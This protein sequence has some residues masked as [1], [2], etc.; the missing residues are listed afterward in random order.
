MVRTKPHA[1]E[2]SRGSPA[3]TLLRIVGLPSE[4]KK[5]LLTALM[6]DQGFSV[7]PESLSEQLNASTVEAANILRTL[8]SLYE[9]VGEFST[10]DEQLEALEDAL[11]RLDSLTG[12][13]EDVSDVAEA[14]FEFVEPNEQIEKTR[15]RERLREG[16]IPNAI[17]FTS[18]V[19]IRPNFTRVDY[20]PAEVAEFVRQIQFVV[21]TDS[22]DPAFETITLQLNEA[23]LESLREMLKTLDTKVAALS[24]LDLKV[25]IK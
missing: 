8:E 9:Y 11:S 7:S 6:S 12:Y 17:G 20:E 15:K 21:V 18:F 22:R 25:P 19:D 4:S 16:F 24:R 13:V 10:R 23:G 14:L 3:W 2:P 1:E 5:A